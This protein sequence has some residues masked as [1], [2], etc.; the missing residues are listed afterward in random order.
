MTEYRLLAEPSADLDIEAAFHWY[1]HEQTGL[2]RQFPDEVRSPY[3]RIARRPL[4]YREIRS[5]IRRG[6]VRR[7]PYA[8]F[9]AVE[10][11][12]VV[13]LAVIHVHRNPRNGSDE[14][15]D[16]SSPRALVSSSEIFKNCRTSR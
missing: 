2:G 16:L 6:L 1:G 5:G 15:G 8:V 11:D 10:G 12:V 4:V 3:D 9:F 7:F 14:G 13:V